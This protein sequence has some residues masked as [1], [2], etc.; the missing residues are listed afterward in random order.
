MNA[1]EV[2]AR[3]FAL[4]G[5]LGDAINTVDNGDGFANELAV[6]A[7][8]GVLSKL[9]H[10]PHCVLQH[11]LAEVEEQIAAMPEALERH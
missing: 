1:E 9:N 4:G 5:T 7:I 6:I 10:C 8:A 11:C 3:V 2:A